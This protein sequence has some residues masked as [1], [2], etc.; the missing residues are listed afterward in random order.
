MKGFLTGLVLAVTPTKSGT[1]VRLAG[2]TPNG[3]LGIT[4]IRDVRFLPSCLPELPVVGTA[5][6]VV[7]QAAYETWSVGAEKASHVVV[8]G[9][10]A[11]AIPVGHTVKKGETL[12]LENAENAFTFRG[13][14][15]KPAVT[16]PV[17]VIEARVAVQGKVDKHFFNLEAWR[18]QQ[19]VLM[20]ARAGTEVDVTCI[21]RRDRLPERAGHAARTLDVMEVQA[22]QRVNAVRL[23]E[24]AD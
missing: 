21:L 14:L 23:S 11:Q 17:G 22:G 16:K 5:L 8:Y 19:G 9:V 7:A 3:H 2:I 6:R 10:R 18:E 4:W 13:H 12:F 15:V 1:L 24:A 20:D